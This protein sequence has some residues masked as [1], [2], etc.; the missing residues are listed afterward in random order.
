LKIKLHWVTIIT[1]TQYKVYFAAIS[2]LL[3]LWKIQ[4]ETPKTES[5]LKVK[6]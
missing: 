6:K 5:F 3:K 1:N 4:F 2:Q